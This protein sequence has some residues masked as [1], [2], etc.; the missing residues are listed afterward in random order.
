MLSSNSRGDNDDVVADY[1]G[2]GPRRCRQQKP[3]ILRPSILTFLSQSSTSQ[4]TS[5]ETSQQASQATI[6]MRKRQS[7]TDINFIVFI[8]IIDIANNNNMATITN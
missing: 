8:T 4:G 3:P 5:K 1:D 6:K 7:H 2:N